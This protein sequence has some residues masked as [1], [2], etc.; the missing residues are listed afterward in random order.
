MAVLSAVL[1]KGRASDGP[2]YNK[3]RMML[4]LHKQPTTSMLVQ[5]ATTEDAA[6]LHKLLERSRNVHLTLGNEDLM[7]ALATGR[8][9]LLLSLIHI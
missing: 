9:L 2:C 5:I 7:A 1:S 6:A 4:K 3:A 8:V